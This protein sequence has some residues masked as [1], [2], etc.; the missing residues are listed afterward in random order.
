VVP[1][2][3]RIMSQAF[4]ILFAKSFLFMVTFLLHYKVHFKIF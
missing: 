1:S 3:L 2:S 4:Q